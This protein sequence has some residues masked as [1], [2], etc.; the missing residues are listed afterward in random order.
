VRLPEL[1]ALLS[2]SGFQIVETGAVGIRDLQ[3]VLA[4][5]RVG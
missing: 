4:K 1:I 5:P 2:D 3:F